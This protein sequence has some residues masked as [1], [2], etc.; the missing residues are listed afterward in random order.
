MCRGCIQERLSTFS[1]PC[2]LFQVLVSM[3]TQSLVSSGLS[4]LFFFHAPVEMKSCGQSVSSP[5]SL[6]KLYLFLLFSSQSVFQ[7]IWFWGGLTKEAPGFSKRAIILVL[8]RLSVVCL[9]RGFDSLWSLPYFESSP[10]PSLLKTGRV[11]PTGPGH[12]VNQ[13]ICPSFHF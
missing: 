13:P 8:W 7:S 9:L 6:D 11:Y 10:P 12:C 4:S 5:S 2:V 1:G 3:A